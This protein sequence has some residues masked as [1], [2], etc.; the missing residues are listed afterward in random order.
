MEE[1]TL[2]TYSEYENINSDLGELAKDI[3]STESTYFQCLAA[4]RT[5]LAR[6][7]KKP[8]TSHTPASDSVT[9]L[10]LPQ[11]EMPPF[12][13]KYSEYKPF[14]EMFSAFIDRDQHLNDIQKLFILEVF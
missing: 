1:K 6:L 5:Q 2:A 8:D 7:A 12:D 10:K 11:V 4:I 9:K 3:E 13:G 14:I